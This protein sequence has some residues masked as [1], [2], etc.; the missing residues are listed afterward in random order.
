VP[1][2]CEA[3]AVHDPHMDS[4]PITLA[5]VSALL[6]DG[7][8]KN[9]ILLSSGLLPPCWL[10]N[11]VC[12]QLY[13]RKDA[14]NFGQWR[15][16]SACEIEHGQFRA[17]FAVMFCLMIQSGRTWQ[18]HTAHSTQQSAVSSQP[19]PKAKANPFSPQSHCMEQTQRAQSKTCLNPTPIEA[20][21]AQVHANLG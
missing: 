12:G 14:K 18:K 6:A 19:R 21:V 10:T 11:A 17:L 8:K 7:S 5:A 16:L 15:F 3:D 4:A 9:R 13:C 1:Q 2:V 20:L